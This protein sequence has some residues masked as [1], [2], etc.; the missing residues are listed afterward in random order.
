MTD[1]IERLKLSTEGKSVFFS[2]QLENCAG[3]TEVIKT[4]SI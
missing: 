4:G 3:Q 2:S 1:H